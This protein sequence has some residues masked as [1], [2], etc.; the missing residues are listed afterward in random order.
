MLRPSSM[1]AKLTWRRVASTTIIGMGAV[2]CL[3]AAQAHVPSGSLP[4]TA[5]LIRYSAGAVT[6]DMLMRARWNTSAQE[7]MALDEGASYLRSWK[8]LP[9]PLALPAKPDAPQLS[10]EQ[11]DMLVHALGKQLLRIHIPRE[12]AQFQSF[13]L[14]QHYP[15]AKQG[16]AYALTAMDA[17]ETAVMSLQ[18]RTPNSARVWVNGKLML[19]HAATRNDS[20][21][22]SSAEVVLAAGKNMILVECAQA[23]QNWGFTLGLIEPD[24][25]ASREANRTAVNTARP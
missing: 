2:V 18:L 9:E 19:T 15:V 23:E 12:K 6:P 21:A 7:N 1:E 25:I 16:F 14:R 24:R 20:V 5:A 22:T 3:S 4:W 10:S 17:A 11:L 8:L 13:D